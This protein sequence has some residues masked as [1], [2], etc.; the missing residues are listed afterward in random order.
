MAGRISQFRDTVTGEP[1]KNIFSGI[2]PAVLFPSLWDTTGR[3]SI[4]GFAKLVVV[5]SDRSKPSFW[6]FMHDILIN[7]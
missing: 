6:R 1:V 2:T 3:I 7:A 4:A 5:P